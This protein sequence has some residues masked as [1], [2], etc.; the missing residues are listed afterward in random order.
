VAETV[1][2]IVAETG[3]AIAAGSAVSAAVLSVAAA[4]SVAV[5]SAAVDSAGRSEEARPVKEGNRP[6]TR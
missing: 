2:E 4:L 3:T 6:S 1:A 5:D